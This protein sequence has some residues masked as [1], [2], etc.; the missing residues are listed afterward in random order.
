ML[1]SDPVLYSILIGTLCCVFSQKLNKLRTELT[2]LYDF[3]CK[4]YYIIYSERNSNVSNRAFK[5]HPINGQGVVDR[6]VVSIRNITIQ[7]NVKQLNFGIVVYSP[8]MQIVCCTFG[9]ELSV[10][11]LVKCNHTL[12][13]LILSTIV[14]ILSGSFLIMCARMHARC[15]QTNRA[16]G[17]QIT[18]MQMS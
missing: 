6:L 11:I 18:K 16:S 4:M 17:L 7:I 1:L 10:S 15:C 14:T 12:E 2:L 8:C 5:S 13:H 3:L 9:C